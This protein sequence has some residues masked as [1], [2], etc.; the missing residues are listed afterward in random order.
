MLLLGERQDWG[1][2]R[3]IGCFNTFVGAAAYG[4]HPKLFGTP[5][6]RELAR[7]VTEEILDVRKDVLAEGRVSTEER[8]GL[9]TPKGGD[10]DE[11]EDQAFP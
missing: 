2:A 1:S 8:D 10:E 6:S 3:Y 9:A 4:M 7:S 5:V 11:D